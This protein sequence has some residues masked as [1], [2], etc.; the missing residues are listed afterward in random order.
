MVSS[1]EQ[2]NFVLCHYMLNTQNLPYTVDQLSLILTTANER[3]I[4]AP[5]VACLFTVKKSKMYF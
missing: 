1:Y 2:T 3:Q 5:F 4:F